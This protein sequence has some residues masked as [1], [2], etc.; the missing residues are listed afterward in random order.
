MENGVDVATGR[1]KQH[2]ICKS[3]GEKSTY[4]SLS[5]KTKSTMYVAMVTAVV[6]MTQSPLV[7]KG[8]LRSNTSPAVRRL[9]TA[10]ANMANPNTKNVMPIL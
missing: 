1:G 7:L 10:I 4:H 2:D 5:N 9:Q 8:I 3:D 6:R